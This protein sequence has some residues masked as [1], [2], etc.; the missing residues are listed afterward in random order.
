[1]ASLA[2]VLIVGLACAYWTAEHWMT[3]LELKFR[4]TMNHRPRTYVS[5][6]TDAKTTQSTMQCSCS[7]N[8]LL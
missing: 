6:T 1:M 8:I 5:D 7:L 3:L 4:V 2:F